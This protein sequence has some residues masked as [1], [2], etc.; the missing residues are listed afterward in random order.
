MGSKVSDTTNGVALN[1]DIGT[2][3]LTDKRFQTAKL[4]NKELVVS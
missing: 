1:L 2:E 3:H 4:Y